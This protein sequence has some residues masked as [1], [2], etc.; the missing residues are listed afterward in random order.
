MSEH[1]HKQK[2]KD[3]SISMLIFVCIVIVLFLGVSIT[4]RALLTEEEKKEIQ[5]HKNVDTLISEASLNIQPYTWVKV[6]MEM[7]SEDIA[8]NETNEYQV[9]YLTEKSHS[10]KTHYKWTGDMVIE[11]WW[12]YREQDEIYEIYHSQDGGEVQLIE[13]EEPPISFKTWD[14]LDN[15]K[16]YTLLE[17]DAMNTKHA[18][19]CWILAI[20]GNNESYDQIVE[21][22]YIDKET[23]MPVT[24]ITVGTK[25]YTK[26]ELE[27]MANESDDSE[28]IPSS[29]LKKRV[30]CTYNYTFSNDD[31]YKIE[32]PK[33]FVDRRDEQEQW[34]TEASVEE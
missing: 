23:V 17:S 28:S 12:E 21:Y 32:M 30:T 3:I 22:L 27:E 34:E 1:K 11:E 8:N 13:F 5:F 26:Q 24:V 14:M 25:D 33:D 10:G 29:S 15:L 2:K 31:T 16:D 4:K 9:E 19:D 20:Y 7:V 18:K 6:D